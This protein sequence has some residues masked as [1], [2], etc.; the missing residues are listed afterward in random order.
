MHTGVAPNARVIEAEAR[1]KLMAEVSLDFT[2]LHASDVQGR[3]RA[4]AS[5]VNGGMA[6]ADAA[7]ASG[8]L[9][10]DE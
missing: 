2:N 4:F 3:A 8:I 6:L 1:D 10:D 5:M 9:I 7:A